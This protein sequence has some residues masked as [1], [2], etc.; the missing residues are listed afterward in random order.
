MTFSAFFGDIK[1]NF[2]FNAEKAKI[3][4]SEKCV[5]PHSA[6]GGG[7]GYSGE[8]LVGVWLYQTQRGACG[9]GLGLGLVGWGQLV[10]DQKMSF[11]HTRFPVQHLKS[12]PVFRPG[13]LE[14]MSS[15]LK[16]RTPTKR[17]LKIYFEFASPGITISFLLIWS[18]N[19]KYI[20]TLSKFPRKPYPIPDQKSKVYTCFYT[21]T[22]QKRYPLGRHIPI[23]ILSDTPKV[24]Y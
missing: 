7:E 12:I 17:F 20:H 11:F 19:D 4:L 16:I 2:Q 15:L 14:L 9:I 22:M 6:G 21:K 1:E 24:V 10:S 5:D 23:F 3:Q 13:H 18:S 8:S